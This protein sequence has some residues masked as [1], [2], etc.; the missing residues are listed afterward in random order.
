MAFIRHYQRGNQAGQITDAIM[1]GPNATGFPDRQSDVPVK[2][3]ISDNTIKIDDEPRSRRI[4]FSTG[5]N[6]KTTFLVDGS[7]SSIH[8]RELITTSEEP[9]LASEGLGLLF[10][11]FHDENERLTERQE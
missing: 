8:N 2:P 4:V 3:L 1:C 7:A 11:W 5:Q 9:E 6:G 10:N